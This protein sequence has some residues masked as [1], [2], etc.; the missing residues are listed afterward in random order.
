VSGDLIAASVA[1]VGFT[2]LAGAWLRA[3]RHLP[4]SRR[5]P[6]YR[7]VGDID[8]RARLQRVRGRRAR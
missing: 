1:V 8:G 3:R 2:S 5:I 6:A 7:I 4:A